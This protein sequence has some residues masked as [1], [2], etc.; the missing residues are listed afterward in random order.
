[1]NLFRSEEHVK[2]WDH[3]DAASEEG[4]MSAEEWA[5]VFSGPPVPQSA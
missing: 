5:Q 4:I 1:M 3:Y 2:A